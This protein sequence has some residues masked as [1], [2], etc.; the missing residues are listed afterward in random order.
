MWRQ[1]LIAPDGRMTMLLN[2]IERLLKQNG[3]S[4]VPFVAAQ[5]L[6]VADLALWRAVGWLSCGVIDGIPSTYISTTFPL[7]WQL[8][9]AVDEQPK[10]QAWKA[11]HPRHYARRR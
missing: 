3:A 5:S 2:G 7:L 1:A 10:V 11:K 6:S 9:C 4:P 8:H